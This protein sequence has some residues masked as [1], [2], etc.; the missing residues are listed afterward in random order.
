MLEKARAKAAQ[1]ATPEA[2]ERTIRALA[3]HLETGD[4]DEARRIV[5]EIETNAGV[6]PIVASRWIT[7]G[8]RAPEQAGE[9]A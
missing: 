4:L 3:T 2:R 5:E 9:A 6:L 8:Q 1:V 7:D